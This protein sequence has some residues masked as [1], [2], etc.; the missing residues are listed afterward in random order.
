[1]TN[2]L[3]EDFE[4]RIRNVVTTQVKNNY[5]GVDDPLKLA[6]F[7]KEIRQEAADSETLR[8]ELEHEKWLKTL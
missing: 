2:P 5:T 3:S 4:L 6:P 7:E 8:S 1:M